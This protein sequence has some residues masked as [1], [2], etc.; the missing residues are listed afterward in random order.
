MKYMPG[1]CFAQ[2]M[3]LRGRRIIEC[4]G[5]LWY[6]TKMRIYMNIPYHEPFDPPHAEVAEMMRKMHVLGVRYPSLCRAGLPSGIYICRQKSYGFSS[7]PPRQRTQVR[8][9]LERCEVRPADETELLIQGLQCN[10]DTME[11]QGRFDAEF[12]IE[13]KWSRLVSAVSKCPAISAIGAFVGGRLAA[14]A[15]T[16]RENGWIH[17]LHQMSRR[18]FLDQFPNHALTYTLTKAASEDS[19][20]EGICFGLIGLSSGNGLHDYKL[21]FGYEV[22]QQ[23]SVFLLHPAIE[24]LFGSSLAVHAIGALRNVRPRDQRFTQ[25]EAVLVG[26]RMSRLDIPIGMPRAGHAGQS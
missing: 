3:E 7:L 8:R 12:A 22:Q 24:K 1:E 2:F 11:R 10:L 5:K 13:H 19:Q 9:A 4:S 18:D 25:I 20:L 26:A 17:I 21:R 23:H 15:I 16:C 14:Y 6:S